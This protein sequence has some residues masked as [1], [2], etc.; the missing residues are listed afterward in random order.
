MEHL[1]LATAR[2]LQKMGKLPAKASF[3]DYYD[4]IRDR[5]EP[6]PGAR[7]PSREATPAG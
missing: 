3:R 6:R 2:E 5:A 4:L 1:I 7:R